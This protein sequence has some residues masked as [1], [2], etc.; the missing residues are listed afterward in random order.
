[1]SVGNVAQLAADLFIASLELDRVGVFDPKHLVPV[2]GARE[3]GSA[4]I[5]TPL[6]RKFAPFILSEE[7]V[8]VRTV[9][10]GANSGIAVVQ[11]RSPVLKVGIPFRQHLS[12]IIVSGS[13]SSKCLSMRFSS[14]SAPRACRH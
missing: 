8:R 5:T 10:G 12:P 13:R 1:M 9:F 3:D 6:E 2:V 11:Q 14:S 7:S 4:G